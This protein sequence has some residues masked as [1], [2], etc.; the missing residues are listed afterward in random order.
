PSSAGHVPFPRSVS[1]L[2][3][4]DRFHSSSLNPF[5]RFRYACRIP[6]HPVFYYKIP[7]PIPQENPFVNF[8]LSQTKDNNSADGMATTSVHKK[9]AK[10]LYKFSTCRPAFHPLYF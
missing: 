3:I 4:S 9:V 6:N 1:P 2:L 5:Q 10:K 8:S 7:V